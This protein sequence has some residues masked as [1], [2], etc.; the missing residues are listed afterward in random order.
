MNGYV[1]RLHPATEFFAMAYIVGIAAVARASL[2]RR[3]AML[4]YGVLYLA[5]SVLRRRAH[6]LD[7]PPDG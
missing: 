7:G 6:R 2:A 4:W 1:V 5:M 3:I